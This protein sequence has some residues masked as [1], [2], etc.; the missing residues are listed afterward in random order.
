MALFFFIFSSYFV[1]YIRK[2]QLVV[3][4]LLSCFDFLVLSIKTQ[5]ISR[6]VTVKFMSLQ[7]QRPARTAYFRIFSADGTLFYSKDASPYFDY[8]IL[9]NNTVQMKLDG[10]VNFQEKRSYYVILGPG[11]AKRAESC[12]VESEALMDSNYWKFIISKMQ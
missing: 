10:N 3:L 2:I 9:A 4:S 11:F 8:R 6:I 7:V 1:L 12:G 5:S